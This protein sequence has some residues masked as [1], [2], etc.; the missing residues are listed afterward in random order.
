M[1]GGRGGKCFFFFW[2]GGG[3]NNKLN[4]LPSYYFFLPFSLLDPLLC[5]VLFGGCFVLT[6]DVIL[7]FLFSRNE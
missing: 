6:F 7:V 4:F 3:I 2:W 5:F 1:V